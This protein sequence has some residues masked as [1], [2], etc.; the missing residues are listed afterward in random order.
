M[1]SFAAGGSSWCLGKLVADMLGKLV[2]DM[3]GKL[4]ANM[5]GKL[6]AG[7]A[8]GKKLNN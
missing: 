2:A 7:Q 8:G 3:L 6:V 5:L 4:V 1:V